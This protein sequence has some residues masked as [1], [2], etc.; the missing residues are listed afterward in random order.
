ML[1]AREPATSPDIPDTITVVTTPLHL[2]VWEAELR[3]HPDG[4]YTQFLMDGI[5]RGFRIGFDYTSH[6][7]TSATRHM[8]SA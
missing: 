4:E 2:Q 5:R 1:N 3:T 7:C 8:K 6:S